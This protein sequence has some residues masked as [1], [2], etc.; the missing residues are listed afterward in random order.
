MKKAQEEVNEYLPGENCGWHVCQGQLQL[1]GTQLKQP[2]TVFLRQRRQQVQSAR[3][4][5][6]L[7]ASWERKITVAEAERAKWIIGHE[8]REGIAVQISLSVIPFY[9][10]T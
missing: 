5:T 6:C 8:M 9:N 10:P 7:T 4:K 3:V 1:S 2:Y